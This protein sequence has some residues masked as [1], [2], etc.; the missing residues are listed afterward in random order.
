MIKSFIAAFMAVF[1]SAVTFL[2]PSPA[3]AAT[4]YDWV[5]G[6]AGAITGF[7]LMPMDCGDTSISPVVVTNFTNV[8]QTG[9]ITIN[10]GLELEAQY[11]LTAQDAENSNFGVCVA[12][13]PVGGSMPGEAHDFTLQPGETKV[14]YLGMGGQDYNLATTSN[15]IAIGGL[16]GGTSGASWYDFWLDLN[17]DDGFHSLTLNYGRTGG[18][19]DN[20]QNGFNAV[21]VNT[22]T[23]PDGSITFQN[24]TDIISPYSYHNTNGSWNGNWEPVIYWDNQPI[25]LAWVP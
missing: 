8:P 13:N 15:N 5:D 2:T 11:F 16:P 3:F 25:G 23:N 20:G 12:R 4:A 17:I 21:M 9:S 19:G 18:P 24:T 6:V 1:L 10:P 14:Y 7:G 22:I